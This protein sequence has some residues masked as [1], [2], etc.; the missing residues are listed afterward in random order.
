M[1]IDIV[2]VFPEMFSEVFRFGIVRQA[3]R[4]GVVKIG[5]H[6]LRDFAQDRHKTVDDRPFGGGEGMV[7]K[8]EP[9]FRAVE[10]CRRQGA[11]DAHVLLLSP[12][13]RRF[14]QE[15][16]KSLSLL[17]HLILLCGRYEGVD[18]RV[19]D[20]LADEEISVGDFVLSGGEFAAMMVADSVI[21]LLP[22]ALGN[23]TSVLEE[24]FMHG[25]LDYPHYT[26]PAEYRNLGIPDVLL[27]GDHR[28]IE[29]WRKRA[30]LSRTR[31]T[32]PDLLGHFGEKRPASKIPSSQE[33]AGS[34]KR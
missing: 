14:D 11:S 26:R 4:N 9:L 17:P 13:G 31:R 20:H 27:S 32:R 7:L 22:G 24:S 12:N 15:K 10:H 6:N 23:P 29:R 8:P 3:R 30:A 16:A 25:I 18:Q 33:V 34:C 2:S 5:I 1:L 21:R 28:R 19:A